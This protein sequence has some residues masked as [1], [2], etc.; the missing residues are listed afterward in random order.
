MHKKIVFI[1]TILTV[2]LFLGIRIAY[3][4]SW[5]TSLFTFI[6]V[7]L[8]HLNQVVWK[9]MNY[10]KS[11]AFVSYEIVLV[12][13]FLFISSFFKNKIWI[14]LSSLLLLAIWLKNYILYGGIMDGD[15]Y[16]KSSIYFLISLVLLNVYNIFFRKNTIP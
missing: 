5:G 6:K 9:E 4:F 13:I 12:L 11:W 16:L 2:F 7:D 10:W 8:L 1:L 14:L 3:N 15:L